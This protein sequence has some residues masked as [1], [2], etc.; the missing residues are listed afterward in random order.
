MTKQKIGGFTT[1]NTRT[2]RALVYHRFVIAL[3]H[4][5]CSHLFSSFA[6]YSLRVWPKLSD[7]SKFTLTLLNE[8]AS[9][10]IRRRIGKEYHYEPRQKTGLKFDG[11]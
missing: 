10:S 1:D 4:D 3:G 2:S 8:N 9:M 6:V 5:P 7:I 11:R